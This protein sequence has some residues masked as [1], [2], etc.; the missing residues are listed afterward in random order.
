MMICLETKKKNIPEN[1][2]L[3]NNFD[4]HDEAFLDTISLIKNLDLVISCDTSIAHIAGSLNC[5][6][7]VPLKMVPDW[8]WMLK[9]SKTPYY[10]SMK[11]YRQEEWGNWDFVFKIMREDILNIN[12][13]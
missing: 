11:L 8:R 6:V 7:W 9:T 12:K 1:I 13:T 2:H 10:P 4:N 3:F 5:P